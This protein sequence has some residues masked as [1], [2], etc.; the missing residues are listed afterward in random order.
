MADYLYRELGRRESEL[1]REVHLLALHYHWSESQILR[2]S[3]R[4]RSLY[5][6]MLSEVRIQ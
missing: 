4:K 6:G 1:Y 3:R 5:L 2:L